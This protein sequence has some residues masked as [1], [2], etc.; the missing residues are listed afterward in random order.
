MA[1]HGRSPAATVRSLHVEC[2]GGRF[3]VSTA[4]S[5][6]S[7]AIVL[8]GCT[9]L[10][11]I[12][13]CNQHQCAGA[14]QEITSCYIK[15]SYRH[16]PLAGAFPSVQSTGRKLA[17]RVHVHLHDM[18]LQNEHLRIHASDDMH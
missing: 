15:D 8:M 4:G 2:T 12:R 18:H 11:A 14:R 9:G 7:T 13:L 3:L 6:M 17:S 5:Q 16:G 10:S 1:R